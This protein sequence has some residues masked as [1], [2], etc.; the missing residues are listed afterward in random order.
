MD[1]LSIIIPVYNGE[2]RIQECLRSVFRQTYD[3]LEVIVIDD[4][5]KDQS[6]E[7]IKD[8]L[9]ENEN[10]NIRVIVETGENR[11]AA[12]A[13]NHGIEIATGEWVTFIDQDDYIIEDYCEKYMGYLRGTDIDILVS[14]YDRVSEDGE[15]LRRVQLSGKHW[16]PFMVVAPWAHIYRRTFLKENNIRFLS[17]YIGEDVYFNLQAYSYTEKI[18]VFEND[19]SYQWVNNLE[20]VSNSRQNRVSEKNNPMSLLNAIQSIYDSNADV[21]IPYQ[22]REYYFIRYIVWYCLFTV[23][24]SKKSEYKARQK[25]L[26]D[27][28]KTHYPDY[29]KNTHLRK[30]VQGETVAIYFAVIGLLLLKTLK[31]DGVLL[32]GLE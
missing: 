7:K 14:G 32:I 3:N 11:G 1:K 30:K 27:W 28:L 24:G 17:T 29:K 5:S 19:S 4:G 25:E 8:V 26:F 15:L 31:L 6:Y 13:R 12:N 10:K 16:D 18:A 20:S 23:R 22:D 21:K 9:V 2:R